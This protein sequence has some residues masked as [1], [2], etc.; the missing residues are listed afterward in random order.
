MNAAVRYD[1]ALEPAALLRAFVEHPPEGFQASLLPSGVPAF[2]ADF[3]LTTTLDEEMCQR[4]Q[5]LPGYARWHKW[6]RW[7]TRFAGCTA[8]EYMPL[9]KG[10]DPEALVDDILRWHGNAS[11]LLVI[12]DMALDSPL[13][14][15]RENRHAAAFIEVLRS[16]G[17]VVLEGMPLAWVAVDYASVDEYIGRLSSS[18]RKDLRRKLKVR[19]QLDIRCV[20]TGDAWFDDDAVRQCYALYLNVHA[21]SEVHFDLLSEDYMRSL[22]RAQ[23][24]GGRM[25]L[26]YAQGELI[27]WNLC[28]VYEGKLVDKYVGFLYPQARQ[29]NLYFVSWIYNLQYALDEGLSHYVAGWTDSR[30]KRYLGASITPTWHAVWARNPLLRLVL[31]RCAHLFQ[32]EADGGG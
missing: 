25:F 5:R 20:E 26:Y 4:L 11:R 29:Y 28:Y 23:D 22:L 24:S 16:R 27:G 32:G 17:F 8:T 12:K 6:L 15:V 9:P 18:R 3:D 14:R 19:D 7:R 13:L 31:R 2:V 21:Q 30:I 1:T 10:A